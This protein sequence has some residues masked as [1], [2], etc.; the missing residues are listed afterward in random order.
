MGS[1]W[2]CCHVD[3][4]FRRVTQLLADG[5]TDV[6][7]LNALGAEYDSMNVAPPLTNPT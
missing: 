4:Y 3:E 6:E 1:L 7:T 5:E 2:W